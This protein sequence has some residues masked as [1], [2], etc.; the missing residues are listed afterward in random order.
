MAG[1][2]E[3]FTYGLEY[4]GKYGLDGETLEVVLCMT[5]T[6]AEVED[7]TGQDAPNLDDITL[8]EFDG[9]GDYTAGYGNRPTL[10][11]FQILVDTAA[12]SLKFK[13]ADVAFPNSLD[14]GSRNV[15]LAI[16]SIKGPTG[17]SDSV[18]LVRHLQGGFPFTATGYPKTIEISDSEGFAQLAPVPLP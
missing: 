6:T 15:K 18:P 7:A 12:N 8:D 2:N 10:S 1:R 16:I 11:S 9:G 13:A 14:P 5:N 17:D 3:W 4:V